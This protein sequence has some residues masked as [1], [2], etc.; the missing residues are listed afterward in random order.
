MDAIPGVIEMPVPASSNPWAV[1]LP[2]SVTPAG[3][4][5]SEEVP[6]SGREPASARSP[7]SCKSAA[8][9]GCEASTALLASGDDA[10]S[11]GKLASLGPGKLASLGPG[12]LASLGPGKPASLGPGK[13]ASLGPGQ[14]VGP[15]QS[16]HAPERHAAV[17]PQG[18]P[19]ARFVQAL[20]ELD[21]WQLWQPFPGFDSPLV[22]NTE[23]I[24]HP[25]WQALLTHTAPTSHVVPLGLGDQSVGAFDG[26]QLWQ[27]S[28]GLGSP[29]A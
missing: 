16:V 26:W 14:P 21:G 5:A 12:K 6:A 9:G 7:A 17:A 10:A 18:F 2:T 4:A 27:A 25:L 8:S 24:Q 1:A 23:P 22:W 19:S 28:S 15:E 11:D 29:L 20:V 13:P 3:R